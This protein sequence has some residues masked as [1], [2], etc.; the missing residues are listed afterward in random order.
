MSEY[1]Q[2][3][4]S[5]REFIR[6]KKN[7]WDKSSWNSRLQNVPDI[8]ESQNI[9]ARVLGVYKSKVWYRQWRQTLLVVKIG[10]HLEIW[11]FSSGLDEN[12]RI[13]E[14]VLTRKLKSPRMAL[15]IFMNHMLSSH[16]N[17]VQC[18]RFKIFSS[19]YLLDI[20]LWLPRFGRRSMRMYGK[21]GYFTFRGLDCVIEDLHL[22]AWEYSST[23]SLCFMLW[24]CSL[25]T[26]ISY[27]YR[28][29][30]IIND[31]WHG[32]L[33]KLL[34]IELNKRPS[35]ASSGFLGWILVQK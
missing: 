21:V 9:F 16:S 28:W 31:P 6:L 32:K 13:L 3:C 17:F 10:I 8:F 22:L 11:L 23:H 19:V 25:W 2:A 34:D 26:C 1:M 20:Q 30:H 7:I 35:Y 12:D 33:S 27:I 24:Y 4:K 5:R 18:C 15:F 29:R 14:C